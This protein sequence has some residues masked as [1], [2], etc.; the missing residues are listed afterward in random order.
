[1]FV[2]LSAFVPFVGNA[3]NLGRA[4]D[5]DAKTACEWWHRA[6]AAGNS[7][8]AMEY[9]RALFHGV[10]VPQDHKA[11]VVIVRKL[12]EDEGLVNAMI[13]LAM[14]LHESGE[15][16]EAKQWLKKAQRH[17]HHPDTLNLLGTCFDEGIAC[18]RDEKTALELFLRAAEGGDAAGKYNAA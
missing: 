8:A 5:R 16:E 9:A 17:A 12:V 2:L 15:T 3:Y 4:V 14:F 1:M 6:S 10:G 7:T 18:E 13:Y 11:A